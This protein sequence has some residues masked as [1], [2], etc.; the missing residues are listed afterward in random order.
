MPAELINTTVDVTGYA[1]LKR[2]A[3]QAHA[4]QI[5]DDSFFLQLPPDAF[6]A[7]FGVEWFI[8]RGVPPRTHETW[9]FDS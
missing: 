1:D 6:R 5:P 7:V 8:H 4:S 3:M 9:L 2:R